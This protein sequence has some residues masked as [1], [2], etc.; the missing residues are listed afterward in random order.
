MHF[1]WNSRVDFFAKEDFLY[2]PLVMKYEAMISSS[3]FNPLDL[4]C[5]KLNKILGMLADKMLITSRYRVVKTEKEDVKMNIFILHFY[6]DSWLEKYF[7]DFFAVRRR[8]S[9]QKSILLLNANMRW[10]EKNEG[11]NVS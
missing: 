5:N 2:D 8:S 10:E 1:N 6:L 9:G 3:K 4:M 7:S 11:Q